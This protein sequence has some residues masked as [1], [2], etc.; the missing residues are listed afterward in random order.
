MLLV[1]G[2]LGP[3]SDHVKPVGDADFVYPPLRSESRRVS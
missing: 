1:N 3:K 2:R